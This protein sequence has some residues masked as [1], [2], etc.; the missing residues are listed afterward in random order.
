MVR[1]AAVIKV[2]YD[3]EIRR[4]NLASADISFE[5]LKSK[6][7]DVLEL[8]G[9]ALRATLKYMDED[10]D[11]VCL[12][13]EDDFNEAIRQELNPFRVEVSTQPKGIHNLGPFGGGGGSYDWNDGTFKGIN[14]ITVTMDSHCLRSIQLHYAAIDETTY[15]APRRGG[16]G[17]ATHTVQFEYPKEKLEKISGYCGVVWGLWTVIK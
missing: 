12:S 1:M 2:R 13:N 4:I 5:D 6:I 8:K 15:T 17:N 11:V 10:G 7:Y 14:G 9:D 3:G 16:L